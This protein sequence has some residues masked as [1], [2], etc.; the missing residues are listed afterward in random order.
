MNSANGRE[1]DDVNLNKL[2]L[3]PAPFGCSRRG[4]AGSLRTAHKRETDAAEFRRFA[5][6]NSCRDKTKNK[7]PFSFF[8][9]FRQIARFL[10]FS[11]PL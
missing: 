1:S 8:V 3:S 9:F 6:R 2:I 4:G 5:E 11:E 7:N 10:I